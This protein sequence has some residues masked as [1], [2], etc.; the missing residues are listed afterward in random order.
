MRPTA[1]N[2]RTLQL[3]VLISSIG[4]YLVLSRASVGRHFYMAQPVALLSMGAQHTSLRGVGCMPY[5]LYFVISLSNCGVTYVA[6]TPRAAMTMVAGT[7][8]DLRRGELQGAQASVQVDLNPKVHILHVSTGSCVLDC[9]VPL[10]NYE[11]TCCWTRTRAD[12]G[13]DCG[14]SG[15]EQA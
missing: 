8:A 15:L 4:Y 1:G 12:G 7:E 6:M 14:A 2:L 13:F 10:V 3:G 9:S 5:L 11:L